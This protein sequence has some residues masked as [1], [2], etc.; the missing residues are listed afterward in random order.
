MQGMEEG[1]AMGQVSAELAPQLPWTML[2]A[3]VG[4]LLDFRSYPE[5]KE[6]GEKERNTLP[7]QLYLQAVQVLGAGLHNKVGEDEFINT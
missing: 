7:A 3:V 4:S 2:C 6:V 5:G 1:K